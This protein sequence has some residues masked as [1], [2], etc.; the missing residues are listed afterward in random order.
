MSI[1]KKF[2][3][4]R[5]LNRCSSLTTWT[6]VSDPVD[7]LTT[8]LL[9]DEHCW[10]SYALASTIVRHCNF[11]NVGLFLVI[12]DDDHRSTVPLNVAGNLDE[13]AFFGIMFD[14][15]YESLLCAII[16]FIFIL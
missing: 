11:G 10:N 8:I 9:A 14:Q 15:K 16:L 3:Q 4:E 2:R 5:C 13:T 6:C 1:F 12:E 7:N